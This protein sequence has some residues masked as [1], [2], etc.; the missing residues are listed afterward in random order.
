MYCDSH[1]Q[2][3]VFRRTYCFQK[4]QI[5]I[6]FFDVVFFFIFQAHLEN[7]IYLQYLL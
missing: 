5:M 3:I 2:W 1:N 7:I 6:V 4:T